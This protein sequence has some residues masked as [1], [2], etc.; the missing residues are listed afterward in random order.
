MVQRAFS[1]ACRLNFYGEMPKLEFGNLIL[2]Y[3]AQLISH[4]SCCEF[5]VLS[6]NGLSQSVIE[7]LIVRR[8]TLF[9]FDFGYHF[10]HVRT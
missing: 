10:V 2:K 1:P 3:C 7:T 8:D 4:Q 5:C 9:P 6:S